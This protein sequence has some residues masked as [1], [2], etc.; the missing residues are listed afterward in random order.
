M[1]K[2]IKLIQLINHLLFLIGILYVFLFDQYNYLL[3]SIVTYYVVGIVGINIGYHRLLSHRSFRTYTPIYYLLTIVGAV[4]AMGSPLAWVAVHRQHHRHS[5]TELDPH[6]P[7]R[8]GPVKAWLGF[9][10]NIK[11]DLRNCKDLRNNKFQRFVH[12]NY[13][14]IQGLY[15]ILLSLIDPLLIIFVYAIPAVLV[16]HSAGAFDV[17]AHMHGY[18]SYDTPDRS[19]NS[20]I[21]NIVTMGEGWHNNHHA[22]PWAWNNRERWWEIDIPALII[23]VIKK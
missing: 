23:R 17:I 4:T 11:I 7:H 10:G 20:W 21:A 19:K 9:W 6:S 13:I 2:K 8:L 18:R 5:D 3:I 14:L 22:K 15:M 12:R 1:T 16:F